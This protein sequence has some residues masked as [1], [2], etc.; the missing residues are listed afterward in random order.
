MRRWQRLLLPT[1]VRQV[2]CAT[3]PTVT[4]GPLSTAGIA[5]AAAAGN[6]PIR[7]DQRDNFCR[8][9]SSSRIAFYADTSPTSSSSSDVA[10]AQSK[11]DDQSEVAVDEE[12]LRAHQPTTESDMTSTH[13]DL[14]PPD[15]VGEIIAYI[16]ED[17]YG[18]QVCQILGWLSAPN[19]AEQIRPQMK[20][21][22]AIHAGKQL[23]T[24]EK[25]QNATDEDWNMVSGKPAAAAAEGDDDGTVAKLVT[26][27]ELLSINEPTRGGAVVEKMATKAMVSSIKSLEILGATA[28]NSLAVRTLENRLTWRARTTDVKD[29]NYLLTFAHKRKMASSSPT[30]E[31]MYGEILRAIDRRWTEISE[32]ET[33]IGLLRFYPGVFDDQ[34]IAKLEDR[35]MEI[36][37]QFSAQEIAALLKA[38]AST[39]RRS[40]PLLKSLT[41]HLPRKLNELDLKSLADVLFAVNKLSFKNPVF[42]TETCDVAEMK[43]SSSS[44]DASSS[45]ES[46]SSSPSLVAPMRSLLTTLGQLKLKHK[47]LVN[48]ITEKLVTSSEPLD[49]KD[50]VAFLLTTAALNYIPPDS[51][52]LYQKIGEQLT[53]ESLSRSSSSSGKCASLWLDVVWSLCVLNKVSSQQLASVLDPNFYNQIFN[54]RNVGMTLKLLNVNA[55]AT[56]IHSGGGDYQG[57]KFDPKTEPLLY[58][59]PSASASADKRKLIEN[60]LDTMASLASPP[61]FL[62]VGNSGGG[63]GNGL[64]TDMGFN[65]E[66]EAVFDNKSLKPLP[67]QDFQMFSPP[68]SGAA[69][70]PATINLPTNST[71]VALMVVGFHDCLLDGRELSGLSDLN[72]RLLEARGCK[73]LFANHWEIKAR[74]PVLDKAKLLKKKL[75][76]LVSPSSTD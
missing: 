58:D 48:K 15:S 29:L 17:L 43:L 3:S 59:R 74:Q 68:S 51:D 73:V 49:N 76:E 1:L 69:A 61:T 35:T 40:V 6:S 71:R 23:E 63:G 16:N 75:Q 45:S 65:V 38:F 21:A 57:P 18:N 42:L 39:K 13:T 36:A 9:F 26:L 54:K 37:P 12:V 66:G 53:P 27:L 11:A 44:E 10:A 28:A 30:T 8:H 47:G 5:S 25:L 41:Y 33:I 70:P 55:Y 20:R 24:Q 7:P 50:L 34:F 4:S 52:K 60:V 19:E 32:A 31:V 67:I 56:H 64:V 22:L 46:S 2:R 72:K 14:A 62:A